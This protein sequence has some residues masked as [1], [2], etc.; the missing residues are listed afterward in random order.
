MIRPET[1]SAAPDAC[2]T[3]RV[4]EPDAKK[5]STDD[6]QIGQMVQLVKDYATQ[7]ALGPV[8]GA[9]RWL[10]FGAAGAFA[11]AIGSLFLV[12]GL[13]R[14]L[15]TEFPGTFG[16]NWTSMW[17]YAIAFGFALLVIG[18]AVSRIGKGTLQRT[19]E[20]H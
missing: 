10:A 9:G 7:E 17:P 8:K 1:T 5:K 16:G 11:I 4:P 18:L 3:Y 20:K 2:Y 19:K 12:L 14:M 15:Q 6:G 13:L